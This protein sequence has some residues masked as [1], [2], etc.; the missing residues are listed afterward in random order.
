MSK[1]CQTLGI[2]R[3]NLSAQVKQKGQRLQKQ[4]WKKKDEELVSMI[5]EIIKERPS[6]GYR[7][8]TACLR[9]KQ[10]EAINPKRVYRV[11]KKAGLLLQKPRQSLTKTHEGKVMTLK[12]NMRWCSDIFTIQC[13]NA[14]QVQVAFSQDCHD[15]EIINWIATPQGIDRFMIQDLMAESL[16][17]RFG[18]VLCVSKPLQWLSDN[19]SPYTAR[20]TVSFGRSLGLKVC[21]T[22]PYSPESNGMAE[23]FVKTFKRDYVAFGNLESAQMV[24]KQLP[25]WFEDYNEKAPHKALKM[26]SPRQYRLQIKAA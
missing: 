16:E 23:A 25:Q 15:R 14:D 4:P 24:L 26:L 8:V 21:T 18:K 2:A 10:K 13:W 3:S 5:Q 20:D 6:Y 19:G 11:M 9:Q 12:S 1:V 22:A 7:R 17:R